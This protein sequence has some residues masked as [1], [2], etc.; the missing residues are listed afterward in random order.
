MHP[1]FTKLS[2]GLL[3][4]AGLYGTAQ[5][6]LIDRGGG[7]IYDTDLD[8]T[9]LQDANYAYTTGY[10]TSSGRPGMTWSQANTWTAGLSYYDSVHDVTYSDWRLP[11]IAD[12]GTSGCNFAYSG[13]DCGY[14]V[15]IATS[16]MAHLYYGE[17]FNLGTYNASGE[18]QSGFGLVNKDPFV[19][20]LGSKYWS[21]DGSASGNAWYFDFGKGYQNLTN[22]RDG[23]HALAVRSG[24]VAAVPEPEIYALMLAGLGLVGF[25]T[26]R[27]QSVN[28]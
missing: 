6:A 5:A 22:N 9:W 15:D 27:R 24:D 8:V 10:I 16:E 26:R 1:T 12:L 14:N 7:L 4:V 19:N 20:L 18:Y 11:S 28:V 17:L 23:L 3:L 21:A 25:T 2:V 13:T